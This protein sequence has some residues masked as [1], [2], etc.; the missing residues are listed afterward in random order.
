M[1]DRCLWLICGV[2][3]WVRVAEVAST[4]QMMRNDEEVVEGVEVRGG[5]EDVGELLHEMSGAG[6]TYHSGKQYRASL[7]VRPDTPMTD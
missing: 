5:L 1:E 2:S 7:D 6:A 4:F 3:V